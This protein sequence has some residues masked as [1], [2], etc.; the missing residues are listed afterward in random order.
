MNLTEKTGKLA[1]QLLVRDDED[2][3]LI[4]ADGTIIRTPVS[5]ISVH[6]RNTQGVRL[7]RVGDSHIMCVAPSDKE[8]EIEESESAESPVETV[9]APD[10][11]D[12]LLNDLEEN[13]E[14]TGE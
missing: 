11:L 8:E 7:M 3:L 4:T 9:N 12:R 14:P 2:I 5:D 1:A 10:A 13:P 6:G